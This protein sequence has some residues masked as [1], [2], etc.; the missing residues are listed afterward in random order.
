MS[1]LEQVPFGAVDFAENPEP[2][3]PCVLLVDTSS[4]MSGGKISALNE[5]LR[6]FAEELKS[7]DMAAKRVEIAV[8]TFGPVRINHDFVTADQFVPQTLHANG[9]TPMGAAISQALQLVADRK[10]IYRANGVG[11][12]RPWVFMITDGAPTDDPTSAAAHIR[13]GEASKSFMFYA[14]GVEGADMDRLRQ[15]AVREPLKL[16][17]LAFREMFV[18]LSNSLGSVSRSTPGDEPPLEN[19]VAPNGWGV[20]GG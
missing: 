6:V 19:P 18:W 14:V 3:C 1:D 15:I 9:D 10:A 11:H 7:D 5:G 2:R 20:A 13:E 8:V 16:K 17:G 12:Y 4:S